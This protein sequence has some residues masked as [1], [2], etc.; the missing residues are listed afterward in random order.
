MSCDLNRHASISTHF[1][2]TDLITRGGKRHIREAG[3]EK[4]ESIMGREKIEVNCK[5]RNLG[6]VQLEQLGAKFK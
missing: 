2:V 4:G 3:K 6:G 1:P 5:K